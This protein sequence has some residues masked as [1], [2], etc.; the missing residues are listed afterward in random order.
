MGCSEA[1]PK[2][3]LADTASGIATVPNGVVVYKHDRAAGTVWLR[4]PLFGR[5][6]GPFPPLLRV[7]S[8]HGLEEGVVRLDGLLGGLVVHRGIHLRVDAERLLLLAWPSPQFL[9]SSVGDEQL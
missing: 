6:L 8:R 7:V 2:Q 3:R 4:L 5:F 1:L 9:E